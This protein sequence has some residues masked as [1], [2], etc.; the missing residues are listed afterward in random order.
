MV[1]S[2]AVLLLCVLLF[3]PMEISAQ[4]AASI[5]GELPHITIS[6]RAAVEV[7]PTRAIISLGVV[8]ERTKPSEAANEGAKALQS[9][10][11]E[12]KSHDID[13]RDIST[14]SITLSAVY[15]EVRDAAGKVSRGNLRTYRAENR[16]RIRVRSVDQAGTLAKVFIDKGANSFRG[17]TFSIDDPEKYYDDLRIRAA[18]DAQHKARL[19]VEALGV[20]LGRILKIEQTQNFVGSEASLTRESQ[21]REAITVAIPIM[22]GTMELTKEIEVTWEIAQ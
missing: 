7:V 14:E 16:L 13:A 22:P 2:R 17:I 18:R 15:D 10:L 12:I 6:G 21:S 11:N 20:K 1:P 19:Y 8:V 4:E 5:R 3:S 9:V